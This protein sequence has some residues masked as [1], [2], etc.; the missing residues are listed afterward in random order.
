MVRQILSDLRSFSFL[1]AS[2]P[3]ITPVNVIAFLQSPIYSRER[4]R[5]LDT[6]SGLPCSTS[7]TVKVNAF[8]RAF[9]QHLCVI[10]KC[11]NIY[12]SAQNRQNGRYNP[13]DKPITF[14]ACSTFPALF[15]YCWCRE[16]GVAFVESLIQLVSLQIEK[17]G[18]VS[19]PAFR[20]L[21]FVREVIRQFFH[22][23]GIQTYLHRALSGPLLALVRD[24]RLAGRVGREAGDVLAEYVCQFAEGFVATVDLVRSLVRYFFKRAFEIGGLE[25]IQIVFYDLLVKPALMNPKLFA[26]LP[27]TAAVAT[28]TRWLVELTRVFW[29][30][31]KPDQLRDK[32]HEGYANLLSVPRFQ[33]APFPELFARLAKYEEPVEGI[34]LSKLQDVTG[35]RYH[36]LLMSVSDVVFLTEI[37][38]TTIDKVTREPQSAVDA[39]KA[40]V[41]FQIPIENNDVVD[42]WFQVFKSPILPDN[43]KFAGE[44]TS[45]PQVYLPLLRQISECPVKS[46]VPLVTHFINYLQGLKLDPQAPGNLEGFLAHQKRRAT[47]AHSTEWLTRTQSI[48]EQIRQLGYTETELF[49]EVTAALAKGLQQS[50]SSLASSFAHQECY[51]ELSRFGKSCGVLNSQLTPVIH[52]AVL[53]NFLAEHKQFVEDVQRRRVHYLQEPESWGSRFGNIAHQFHI[54][55][56][57]LGLGD[58]VQLTRQLHS[59]LCHYLRFGEFKEQHQAYGRNDK[60]L[61]DKG[62]QVLDTFVRET[63]EEDLRAVF[64]HPDKCQDAIEILTGRVSVAGSPLEMLAHI[65]KSRSLLRGV[66]RFD[67]GE[68]ADADT[69]KK[70]LLFALLKAHVADLFSLGK[71]VGSFLHLAP[72]C[73]D[74]LSTKERE[75]A[76]L[77]ESAVKYI[78]DQCG[79]R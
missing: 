14:F 35:M 74:L 48:D 37:V 52:Q 21:S 46:A 59:E 56:S 11:A 40:L 32:R 31:V 67:V 6:P 45:K 23:Q 28:D 54:F 42:F 50:K 17:C 38:L 43:I 62:S 77:F 73:V 3:T 39:L 24:K 63:V 7:V 15:G 55:V 64:E 68:E 26:I 71:Y 66:Y 8:L 33:E 44:L 1:N 79:A 70:L 49:E 58:D 36:L 60:L 5:A 65:G 75:T 19:T 34:S 2:F 30:A 41:S 53:M 10:C 57:A 29:Y 61:F 27:E 16:Q 12:F 47:Q 69:Q 72:D 51:D 76:A 25:L 22:A 9:S 4:R 13:F 18:G 78:C 20:T